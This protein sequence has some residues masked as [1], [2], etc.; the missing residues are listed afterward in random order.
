M[1]E[2][3]PSK[4][5]TTPRNTGNMTFQQCQQVIDYIQEKKKLYSKTEAMTLISGLCQ[6]GGTNRNA[7]SRVEYYYN[8]RALNGAEFQHA[9]NMFQGTPRQFAR[10][11]ADT[12]VKFAEALDEPGDLSR[13]MKLEYPGLTREDSY[14]CSNY[15]SKNPNCPQLVQ[16]WLKDD[17]Y[18][19]FSN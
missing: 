7:G 15:Q 4:K 8:G 11:M 12:I 3:D 18:K 9:C 19:R 13:Q 14:W 5:A 2:V 16:K 1:K 10:T 6:I 17:Y